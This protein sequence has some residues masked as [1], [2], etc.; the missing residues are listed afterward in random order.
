MA[1]LGLRRLAT[2]P[3]LL[4]AASCWAPQPRPEDWLQVGFRDP[5]QTFRTYQTAFATDQVDLEYRCLSVGMK[6]AQGIDSATYRIARDELLGSV[7]G[8]KR[9]AAAKIRRSWPVDDGRWR[10][11]AQVEVLWIDKFLLVELVREEFFE[12]YSGN[13][14]VLDGFADFDELVILDDSTEPPILWAGVDAADPLGLQPALDPASVDEL[15][16]GREWKIDSLV[17][18]TEADAEALIEG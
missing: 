18:L 3:L 10:L 15:R 9:V 12:V 6:Q 1:P 2:L 5:E 4:A 8:L 14:R 13:E 11:I 17:P 7:P 16:V